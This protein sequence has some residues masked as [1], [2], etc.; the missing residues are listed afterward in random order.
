M[1]V[2]VI[3][4]A[5]TGLLSAVGASSALVL[6]LRCEA[7]EVSA[8]AFM[9]IMVAV[10]CAWCFV[11]AIYLESTVPQAMLMLVAAVHTLRA[12]MGKRRMATA[13]DLNPFA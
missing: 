4:S 11:D 3:L 6:L 10:A 8:R 1:N 2:E 13:G 9:A 12:I 5:A 7:Y